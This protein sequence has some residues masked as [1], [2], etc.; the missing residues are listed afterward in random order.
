MFRRVCGLLHSPGGL[1][2]D[3]LRSQLRG[4]SSLK[5]Q[6]FESESGGSNHSGGYDATVTAEVFLLELDIWIRFQQRKKAEKQVAGANDSQNENSENREEAEHVPAKKN[7][8]NG[9]NAENAQ[10]TEDAPNAENAPNLNGEKAGLEN[11]HEEKK[12][13]DPNTQEIRNCCEFVKKEVQAINSE[14]EKNVQSNGRRIF[15]LLEKQANPESVVGRFATGNMETLYDI[16][17]RNGT[18]P[19]DALKIYFKQHYC[20]EQMRLVTFGPQKL[21]EQLE[22]VTK[23]GFHDLSS[24]GGPSHV[25]CKRDLQIS[26]GFQPSFQPIPC[27][28]AEVTQ[29]VCLEASAEDKSCAESNRRFELSGPFPMV[30]LSTRS[31]E[32]KAQPLTYM[33]Y[34]MNY[35]GT[36]AGTWRWWIGEG[37]C[38]ADLS[39]FR[40]Q[41]SLKRV[42]SDDLGL[43][44]DLEM[45]V[46][47]TTKLGFQKSQA[48]L[49]VFFAYLASIRAA[50]VDMELYKSIQ[51]V[52]HTARPRDTKK[53]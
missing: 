27:R 26:N 4:Q 28:N 23:A 15:Q 37:L 43:I 48:I 18:S 14:H 41:N 3:A 44:V 29:F 6:K 53:L 19:V 7:A 50:G 32:F 17:K 49:D 24:A 38:S 20:P 33:N 30:F 25:R 52:L 31:Q 35:G 22:L 2:L 10:H 9:Q 42:L 5:V 1:N 21:T 39:Q 34:V 8:E 16:P 51:A 46:F 13:N 12:Q 11:G 36:L 47:E 45:E 40:G